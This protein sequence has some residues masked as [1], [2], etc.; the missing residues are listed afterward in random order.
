MY[1]GYIYFELNMS[2]R[3]DT[4]FDRHFAWLKYITYHLLLVPILAP[5]YKVHSL[6]PAKLE[7]HVFH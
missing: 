7:K 2:A 4:Y 3:Q 6:S 1:E 5:N